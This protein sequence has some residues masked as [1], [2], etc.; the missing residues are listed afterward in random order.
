M[1]KFGR[2]RR[3][4]TVDLASRRKVNERSMLLVILKGHRRV[5]LQSGREDHACRES[6]DRSRRSWST[7][8][9]GGTMMSEEPKQ[10][11][12]AYDFTF[13]AA[14]RRRTW[15]CLVYIGGNKTNS[16]EC[17]IGIRRRRRRERGVLEGVVYRPIHPI[18]PISILTL[19]N[20]VHKSQGVLVQ[21]G[22][23]G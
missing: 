3:R 9:R 16:E 15:V 7:V 2:L 22:L 23:F 18:Y 10:E 20:V 6:R 8:T 5:I 19:S 11:G 12:S 13:D 1:E 17:W 14:R 4:E 21:R